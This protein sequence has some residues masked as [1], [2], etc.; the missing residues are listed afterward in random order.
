MQ[1]DAQVEAMQ[2]DDQNFTGLGAENQNF[3]NIIG[4][5]ERLDFLDVQL[6]RKFYMTGR[7]FPQDTQ[8]YC[9]PILFMEMKVSHKMPI[10]GEALRKRLDNLVTNGLLVKA[11]RTN[12]AVY[13]PIRGNEQKVRAMITRFFVVNG[14]TKFI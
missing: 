8:P 3:E 5:A 12:P 1:V 10:G 14:L 7:D 9:F 6:L 13:E 11:K 4:L 2:K